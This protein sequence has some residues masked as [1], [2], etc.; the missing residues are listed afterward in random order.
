MNRPHERLLPWVT[1]NNNNNNY[2]NNNVS[3]TMVA[4]APSY[5]SSPMDSLSHDEVN[6]V[7]SDFIHS[8]RA[9]LIT[10]AQ[11]P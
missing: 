11:D 7:F 6:Q 5:P 9:K 1:N 2:N 8:T 10:N 3:R 4:F